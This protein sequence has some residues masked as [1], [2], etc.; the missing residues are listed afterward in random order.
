[1]KKKDFICSLCGKDFTTKRGL[2]NHN[3]KYHSE[4]F[5]YSCEECG[6]LFS[7]L[8][9]L[10]IHTE[11]MHDGKKY[12]NNYLK[13]SL[14]CQYENCD[15]D[16]QYDTKFGMYCSKGHY[17]TQKKLNE[18]IHLDYVCDDCGTSFEQVGGLQQHLTKVH[19]YTEDMIKDYYDSHFKKE[20]DGLCNY[21]KKKLNFT[22]RFTDGYRKFCYNTDCN[23]RYYNEND[24]RQKKASSSLSNRHK[25][26]ATISPLKVEYYIKKG[27]SE[28]DAKE[29][30]S[31]RQRTFTKEKLIKKYGEE[32]G[33]NRWVDRQEKWMKNFP[34]Q[35]YSMISQELFWS[36]YDSL[37][38][39]YKEIYFATNV[40]GNK[41]IGVNKEYRVRTK[42]TSRLLD[43]YIKDIDKVIEFDGTYWHGEIGSGNRT[44]DE[45][46]ELEII[47]SFPTMKMYHVKEKDYNK[48]KEKVIQKCL[49]FIYG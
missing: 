27:H 11:K 15:N 7:E 35:N 8:K 31:E 28:K 5:D 47:E 2:H 36:L 29:L 24:G 33:M 18:G 32:E 30:L 22:G 42:K 49:E 23:V 44:R 41:T 13:G 1:M 40:N 17:E 34:K 6:K 21:C 48:D 37:K 9:D 4:L 16:L 20:D 38:T 25:E 26:D 45:E 10:L 3:Q 12:F 14:K 43:F 46:R 19:S 39:K